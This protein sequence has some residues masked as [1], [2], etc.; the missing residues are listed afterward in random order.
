MGQVKY[1]IT[2]SLLSA[3]SYLFS[4][5]EGCEE[6]AMVDFL[7]ALDRQKKEQTPA[8]LNGIEF[9]DAVYAQAHGVP[10]ER[11]PKWEAGIRKV[12]AVIG[13]APVQVKAKRELQVGDMTFLVY[14]ILDALSA[15]VIYDV[16]FRNK[17]LGSEDIYGKYLESPQHPAYFYIVPE[18][19]EFRYLVS[20][21]EDVYQEV[22]SREESPHIRDVIS[23]FIS[24]LEGMG[25]LERYKAHWVAL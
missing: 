8:M 7:A 10:R 12:A 2:Q 11:H 17:S 4:C 19:N 23:Q 9:E 1:L 21:G 20:D 25:L 6:D 16:K 18:A 3:W 13:R 14:G 5:H 15:G 24:S 22:Y